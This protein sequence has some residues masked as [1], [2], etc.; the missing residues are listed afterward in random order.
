MN[1]SIPYVEKINMTKKNKKPSKRMVT[2]V[3]PHKIQVSIEKKG[4]YYIY[5][6]KE[7]VKMLPDNIYGKDETQELYD[8]G[9][10]AARDCEVLKFER[11]DDMIHC[12][13]KTKN[14]FPL[15][16][17]TLHEIEGLGKPPVTEEDNLPDNEKRSF[18]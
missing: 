10:V 1:I 4:K 8:K 13:L 6:Y 2:W 17:H 16:V 15:A 11:K 18:V 7:W 12:I 14:P 9:Y 5:D 3:Y